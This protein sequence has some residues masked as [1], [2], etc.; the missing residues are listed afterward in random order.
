MR[1]I[2]IV[3]GIVLA[4]F[5]CKSLLE[6]TVKTTPVDA[7]APVVGYGSS[8]GKVTFYIEKYL[9]FEDVPSN[10][11]EIRG[12][13]TYWKD[14]SNVSVISY[15]IWF[16]DTGYVAKDPDSVKLYASLDCTAD[17]FTCATYENLIKAAGY[18]LED[19]DTTFREKLLSGE[20]QPG[21]LVPHEYTLPEKAVELM[22]RCLVKGGIYQLV[23]ISLD[24]TNVPTDTLYLKELYQEITI[25]IR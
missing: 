18:S 16:S 11:I 10:I 13:K 20:T 15:T 25:G 22:D 1:R 17:T 19:P 9:P 4:V 12:M 8:I 14:S 5:G 7:E 23:Q 3:A 24:S 6:I 21:K 2:L